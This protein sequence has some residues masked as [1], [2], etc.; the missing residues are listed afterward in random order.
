MQEGKS[1]YASTFQAPAHVIS[2][3]IPLFNASHADK[4]K[5]R[6]QRS[7]FCPPRSQ[8]K[9]NSQAQDQSY[10][11]LCSLHGSEEGEKE[12]KNLKSK[13]IYHNII[14]ANSCS[15]SIKIFFGWHW[16]L[17]EA[18]CLSYLA[19]TVPGACKVHSKMNLSVCLFPW[20]ISI[21]LSIALFL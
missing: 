18:T 6:G 19:Q 12:V 9:S 13:L 20:N 8:S 3:T 5:F 15:Y 7:I 11:E 2:D 21:H 16:G 17:N 1:H 10:G 4:P 14:E